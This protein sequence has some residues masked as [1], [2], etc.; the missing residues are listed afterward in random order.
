MGIW[1]QILLVPDRELLR[2]RN[3]WRGLTQTLHRGQ[4]CFGSEYSRTETANF[5]FVRPCCDVGSDGGWTDQPD[6]AAAND[7]SWGLIAAIL[8]LGIASSAVTFCAYTWLLTRTSPA[9]AGT[10][11]F[12]NPV[13]ALFVGAVPP[14][15]RSLPMKLAMSE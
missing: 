14:L 5:C 15:D 7:R 10:Y 2:R 12:V 6:S 8:Y 11:A 9:A 4:D 3:R 13:V 1:Q